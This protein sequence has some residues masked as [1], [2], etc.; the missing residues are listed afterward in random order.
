MIKFQIPI[1]QCIL[2]TAVEWEV[3][4]WKRVDFKK[5]HCE[6]ERR[7]NLFSKQISKIKEIKK[8]LIIRQILIIG[9]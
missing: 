4:R 1:F 3:G 2:R 7:S 6:K 5:R 8:I 9:V